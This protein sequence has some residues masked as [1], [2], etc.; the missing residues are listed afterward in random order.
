MG[1]ATAGFFGGIN[2]FNY[3]LSH[4]GEFFLII[5]GTG[6]VLGGVASYLAVRRYLK[7]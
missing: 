3:Y 1:S 5:V 7:I 4:F 2:V 6:V